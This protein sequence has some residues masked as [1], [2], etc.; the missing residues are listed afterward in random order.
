ME[1]FL[2]FEEVKFYEAEIKE[3]FTSLI[4][5]RWFSARKNSWQWQFLKHCFQVLMG[6]TNK[7]FACSEKQAI[8]YKYEISERLTRYYLSYGK[9]LKFVFSLVHEKNDGITDYE[10]ASYPACNHYLLRISFNNEAPQTLLQ[11]RLLIEKT[12]AE[13]VDAEWTVYNQI[14]DLDFSLLEKAF[15]KSGSAYK[16]ICHIANSNKNRGWTLQNATN[17]STKRLIDVKIKK[18]TGKTAQARTS[19]Y[20]LLSWWSVKN[21]RYEHTYKELNRQTYTLVW[22]KD[23]WLVLDNIYPPP[24]T[25]T[26]R[27]NILASKRK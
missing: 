17:P 12:L 8:Q 23:K 26:P 2:N 11:K 25:S 6:E 14:P 20:W 19:E 24:K 27:R 16:L 13:A 4:N 22:K 10:E 7:D 21:E 5:H 18:M 9:P 3:E 1:L 15:D